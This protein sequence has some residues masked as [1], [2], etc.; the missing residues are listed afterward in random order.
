METDGGV[1]DLGIIRIRVL[2]VAPSTS[3][4]EITLLHEGTDKPDLRASEFIAT[5]AAP[6]RGPFGDPSRMQAGP[7][8]LGHSRSGDQYHLAGRATSAR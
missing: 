2:Q 5:P 7:L 4:T 6:A 3:K 8:N 1:D